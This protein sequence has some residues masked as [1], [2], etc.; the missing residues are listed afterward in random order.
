MKRF[1]SAFLSAC[2]MLSLI[3][4]SN[5]SFA[6]PAEN[7]LEGT[8]FEQ[9]FDTASDV[10]ANTMIVNQQWQLSTAVESETELQFEFNGVTVTEAYDKD[11]HFSSYSAAAAAWEQ[12]YTENGVLN[13]QIAT[14]V[15]NFILTEGTYSGDITVRFSANIYGAFAGITPN[16]PTFDTTSALPTGSWNVNDQRPGSEGE[17]VIQGKILRSNIN[18]GSESDTK[19]EAA[20]TQAQVDSYVLNIDGVKFTGSTAIL[21]NDLAYNTAGSTKTNTINVYNSVFDGVN[22][23][24]SADGDASRNFNDYNLY[25]I[26]VTGLK[27]DNNG[28]FIRKYPRNVYVERMNFE[29]NSG[30]FYLGGTASNANDLW[31]TTCGGQRGVS[32]TVKDSRFADNSSYDIIHS[33]DNCYLPSLE[34]TFERN[35]FKNAAS[36]KYGIFRIDTFSGS[37]YPIVQ[38][39]YSN[40]IFYGTADKGYNTVFNGNPKYQKAAFDIRFN[41]NRVIGYKSMLMSITSE[42]D[43]WLNSCN[44]DYNNNYFADTFISADDELGKKPVYLTNSATVDP[45]DLDTV[46]YFFDYNMTIGNGNLKVTGAN[47]QDQIKFFSINNK[48][49]TITAMLEEG[50]VIQNP[51]FT[52]SSDIAQIGFWSDPDFTQ[53]VTSISYDDLAD[54]GKKTYYLNL[55]YKEISVTYSVVFTA[56]GNTLVFADKFADELGIIQSTAALYAADGEY[57]SGSEVVAMW[58]NQLYSFVAGVNAFSSVEEARAA[59]ITQLILPGGDYDSIN[60]NGSI[61]LYGE[62]YAVNPNEIPSERTEDWTLAEQWE[63]FSVANVEGIVVDA[64]ATPADESGTQITVKGINLTGRFI[65]NRRQISEYKTSILLENNILGFNQSVSGVT[66]VFALDNANALSTDNSIKNIDEFTIKNSRYAYENNSTSL[67]FFAEICPA[68]VTLDGIYFGDGFITVGYPKWRNCVEDGTLNVSNCYFK[69]YSRSKDMIVALC[70]HADQCDST[71]KNTRAVFSNN[72]AIDCFNTEYNTNKNVA[73]NIFPGAF[74]SVEITD[75][76]FIDTKNYLGHVIKV[77]SSTYSNNSS[78][79]SDRIVFTGNRIIG[80][81]SFI[82]VNSATTSLDKCDG[83]YYARYTDDYADAYGNNGLHGILEGSDCYL[84]FKKTTLASE[85]DM[86][87]DRK[88]SMVNNDTRQASIVIEEDEKYIPIIKS[89]NGRYT[90]HLFDDESCSSSVGTLTKDIVGD[91]RMFWAKAVSQ[92]GVSNVYQ[93]YVTVGDLDALTPDT[94]GSSRIENPYLFYLNTDEMP[95]GTIFTQSWQGQ[96]YAFTAG[97]NAFS[98]ISQII[99]YHEQ[100]AQGTPNVILPGGIYTDE[101][102]VTKTVNIYG[103]NS[104]TTVLADEPRTDGTVKIACVGDSITEGIGID[105]SLRPTSA[106][107]AQ[108]QTILDNTYGQGKYEVGNFG[109]GGSTINVQTN[110]ETQSYTYWTYIYSVQYYKSLDFNPDI[111]VIMMGHNDTHAQLYTTAE[112]YKEQYQALIDSYEALPSHPTVVV[113]GC[114]S[115]TAS[116]RR[117]WLTETIIPM[118]KEIARDNGLIYI[119]MFTPTNGKEGD[120]SLF[121]DGLHCTVAGYNMLASLIAD[122]MSPL[123]TSQRQVTTWDITV[124]TQQQTQQQEKIKVACVGDSLTYGDKAYKGYPVYL[125]EMLGD[126]YEVRNFGECGA[127]ACDTSTFNGGTNWCYKNYERYTQSKAWQP[128]IVIMMLGYND[129]GGHLT[130]FHNVS[131]SGGADSTAAAE[132]EKDYKALVQEYIDLGAQVYIA[133]TPCSN[134]ASDKNDTSTQFKYIC[135]IIEK[136]ANELGLPFIDIHSHTKPWSADMYCGT[137]IN[138]NTDNTH[139]SAKGYEAVASFMFE[140]IFSVFADSYYD[141]YGEITKDAVVIDYNLP[142]HEQGDIVSYSWEG[143]N[144]Q[145]TWGQNAFDSIDAAVE[146]ANELGRTTVQ[147]L[148]V[149]NGTVTSWDGDF[150]LSADTTNITSIEVF[151]QNR[152]FD[153]NDKSAASS[154]PTADWTLNPDWDMYSKN[155][156]TSAVNRITINCNDDNN[157]V[158][159][160]GILKFKGITMRNIVWNS[161]RKITSADDP[162]NLDLIFENVLV[163]F[164][165]ASGSGGYLFNL[166]SPR[167]G[168]SNTT[169][170]INDSITLKNFRIEK[171]LY[172]SGKNRIFATYGPNNVIIDGFYYDGQKNELDGTKYPLGQFGWIQ[173]APAAKSSEI[174]ILNSNFR[175][176]NVT[177]NTAPINNTVVAS[178]IPTDYQIRNN[179]FYNVSGAIT[180]FPKYYSSFTVENN[181]FI[182]PDGSKSFVSNNESHTDTAVNYVDTIGYSV[183]NNTFVLADISKYSGLTLNS[184]TAPSIDLTGSYVAQYTEDYQ[185]GIAGTEPTIGK[186]D[187]FYIDFIRSVSSNDFEI[188]SLGAQQYADKVDITG[189]IITLTATGGQVIT[190]MS[191]VCKGKNI[192]TKIYSDQQLTT[193][194]QSFELPSDEPSKTYWIKLSYGE[195]EKVYT[196]EFMLDQAPLFANSFTD[197]NGIINNTAIALIPSAA[198]SET[199]ELISARWN[200]KLYMFTVG[201]NAFATTEQIYEAF[202]DQ[203]LQIIMPAGKYTSAIYVYGSWEVY[204]QGYAVNPNDTTKEVW[205]LSEDW[206]K[207]G[208]TVI[209]S[210]NLVIAKEAT[211][212]T[213]QGTQI[214]VS[215]IKFTKYINDAQRELSP[216]KTTITFKNNVYDRI[217]LT[218]GSREFD[219]RNKNNTCQDES[220]TNIDELNIINFHYINS[221]PSSEHALFQE[222]TAPFTTIDGFC[223]SASSTTLGYPKVTKAAKE[224]T[225]TLKNSFFKDISDGSARFKFIV[226]L[227][228][229]DQNVASAD[230]ESFAS[231]LNIEN[232]IFMNCGNESTGGDTQRYVIQIFP[233]AYNDINITGND[234]ISTSDGDY[235]FIDWATIS[236]C[237][238]SRDYSDNISFTQN[239]LIGTMPSVIVNDLTDIDLSANYFAKYTSDYSTAVMGDMPADT[240]ADYYLDY[241]KTVKLSDLQPESAAGLTGM[242]VLRETKT[243][244]GY[245]A[246]D[247]AVP[248]FEGD[249]QYSLYSDSNCT[250]PLSDIQ[251]NANE[252]V[253]AYVKAVKDGISVV[254]TLYVMGIDDESD[255]LSVVDPQEIDGIQ[256]PAVYYPT[257]YGAP[258]GIVVYAKYN[259]SVY[260]FTTGNRVVSN[261]P[262]MATVKNEI[263]LPDNVTQFNQTLIAG[264]SI[265]SASSAVLEGVTTR[266]MNI[267]CVGDSIT[268]GVGADSSTAYPTQ[269]QSLLG[270]DMFTVRNFGKSAATVQIIGGSAERGY[271]EFAKTEYQAS[272]AFNPDVVIFAL[273]TN[274][275]YATRWDS[276]DDYANEYIQL[277]RTYQDLPS[278]PAIYITT[279]LKRADNLMMNERVEQNL[280]QLQEYVARAVGAK[281]IDTHEHMAPY[282]DGTTVYFGDNL[283]PTPAG[284]SVM[285]QFI[286]DEMLQDIN[287]QALYKFD[288]M[289][290]SG[291][292]ESEIKAANISLENCNIL[293]TDDEKCSVDA[294]SINTL[295]IIDCTFTD[296]NSTFDYVDTQRLLDFGGDSFELADSLRGG[297]VMDGF[298]ISDS[299]SLYARKNLAKFV[300]IN[301]VI[302]QKDTQ[303]TDLGS[304][305]LDSGDYSLGW[306][307]LFDMNSYDITSMDSI[308]SVGA[309]SAD[310]L[311]EIS[312]LL[313]ELADAVNVETTF[314]GLDIDSDA[315]QIVTADSSVYWN[316]NEQKFCTKYTVTSPADSTRYTVMW[317]VYTDVNGN[318][319]LSYSMPDAMTAK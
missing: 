33:N 229:H 107:P 210:N 144:Y 111:V 233:Q 29:Q 51:T 280:I 200:G 309:V 237:Q 84:D 119:D 253:K 292:I 17:T 120:K 9:M 184:M 106:Y 76:T 244:F 2:I 87:I 265:H 293:L 316:D 94:V 13:S 121:T 112:L 282:L 190:D 283:H 261:V 205:S 167:S 82:I 217:Y 64:S 230:R 161:E 81:T 131:W 5:L 242:T 18:G 57:A 35:I 313:S 8:D 269:L 34:F 212:Q 219:F 30:V 315:G 4:T 160:S 267:A 186:C 193:E 71:S 104:D 256:N 291:R 251:V 198:D 314:E 208:E 308:V 178:G 277:I 130:D 156:G 173:T 260:G 39:D 197:E 27:S 59:G 148:L 56:L 303:I 140:E 223:M 275:T 15:P 154:D 284:Y 151:G 189:D 109:W 176:D 250:Q 65:D 14:A 21:S 138:G 52:A 204:G 99:N 70:G 254:Y 92:S 12:R 90:Y 25:D 86:V 123:L 286:A 246:Q 299:T 295:D 187:Y 66:Y 55:S 73:V 162:R 304:L 159:T 11:R 248:G 192:N 317:I 179:V 247:T 16:D 117:D 218:G 271:T 194:A 93:V 203:K 258:D 181:F 169:M 302:D 114:T 3:S 257:L 74:K 155:G 266:K 188:V 236:Y 96:N 36:G 231:V 46:E 24:L 19:Y 227:S 241:A 124:D 78:D 290:V 113:A 170:P 53:P 88:L 312:T 224:T 134:N 98:S 31:W 143:K 171:F 255:I 287:N 214:V 288:S 276:N 42:M 147:A 278:K 228:G 72:I 264:V 166:N 7:P 273:G 232:N 270:T 60:I 95:E 209:D 226:S 177:F 145:F 262:T 125:Q 1:L 272:L 195:F 139:F 311:T 243:I 165:A 97:V 163:D 115:R 235:R 201:Q 319:I 191:V 268:Q 289:T 32:F 137:N 116:I 259:G 75:N 101:I 37:G 61:E 158:I 126:R 49:H 68:Y 44:W 306:Y 100:N 102:V 164:T 153:P 103:E 110:R 23:G 105:A 67:R 122:G 206:S 263:I 38:L 83:N 285:A 152:R 50:T 225:Y 281:V 182:Q 136:V 245:S 129:A 91:G 249:A 47:F 174:L 220:F 142:V 40:N 118:Q 26:R 45:A 175:N 222:L 135:P 41:Y 48:N 196:L 133:N 240:D 77:Q 168:S 199:G 305:L 146:K 128:D 207:N 85:M 69:N 211:P 221:N 150:T 132:F 10:Y 252:A 300:L 296:I 216:Y 149:E 108:L 185:N 238:N 157:N 79:F 80:L 215:G 279:A 234:V 213:E 183:K 43:T 202:P 62:G 58:Q 298:V 239:R 310:N 63:A 274:D 294:E 180:T 297:N 54:D 307:G 127:I 22:Y 141:Q 28:S 301:T 172:K 20:L 6:V 318:E 89:S